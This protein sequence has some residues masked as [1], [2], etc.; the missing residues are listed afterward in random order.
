[1]RSILLDGSNVSLH[2]AGRGKLATLEGLARVVR[3]LLLNEMLPYTVFDASFRYRTDENSSARAT[4][5]HL[6]HEVKE[7]F[8]MSPRGEEADLFL[9]E[10]AL[11][12]DHPVLSNDT[13]QKYGGVKGG[14]LAYGGGSLTVCNFQVF[15]GTVIVPDL[16]IRH[17]V[18]P[19]DGSLDGIEALLADARARAEELGS[20]AGRALPPEF[21]AEIARAIRTYVNGEPKPLS[22]LGSLLAERKQLYGA[23]LGLTKGSGKT[24]FGERTLTLFIERRFP[25][26]EVED[27]RIRQAE[28]GDPGKAEQ[29]VG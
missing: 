28:R 3:C 18:R 9:L 24:W 15:A 26:Y 5:D 14:V 16:G 25:E 20:Q 27:G 4:F 2:C 10:M 6:T 21:D 8:Q 17:R 13:F 1:M 7:F 19:Q 12:G 11:A 23:S 22:M 29:R